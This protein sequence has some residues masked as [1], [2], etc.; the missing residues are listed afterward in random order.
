MHYTNKNALVVGLGKSGVAVAKKLAFLGAS[1]RVT[2]R[3]DRSAI[4]PANIREL[5]A[6]GIKLELGDPDLSVLGDAQLVV[7]SPGVPTS[8]RLVI[9]AWRRGIPVISEVE[10]AWRFLKKPIIAITGTN[11]KTTTTTLIGEFLKAA[12]KK[13]AVAGNI[14]YPLVLVNDNFLDFIVVELS[15]YQLETI[16]T[17]RPWISVILNLSEDHL[18]RHKSM[19]AYANAK[20][21]IFMNQGKTD[22]LIYNGDDPLVSAMVKDAAARLIPFSKKHFSGLDPSSIRLKG[23]HNLENILAASSA[24]SLAG[25]S[26]Q[27]IENVLREFAGVEHRIE[28]VKIVNG[29]SFYNDSKATNPDS[30]IVA[31][32]ALRKEGQLILILGGEDKGTDIRPMCEFIKRSVK[33]VVLLG[34]S[35]RRFKEA[36]EEAGYTGFSGVASMEEAVL[37]AYYSAAK[38]DIV[39]LSP[40]CASFDMFKNFEE[41]GKVFKEKVNALAG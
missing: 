15:S 27:V 3:A 37:K 17:F 26:R 1:V 2:D 11:G 36:L 40:A 41:R 25:V 21:R 9:E 14:G 6:L 12:G 16:K 13:A 24:A 30:T 29:I 28:F 18:A 32:R 38:G 35:I 22:Y 33:H 31:L 39:L 23:E 10:F 19:Q 20:A 4:D 5:E 8:V 7:L 34:S